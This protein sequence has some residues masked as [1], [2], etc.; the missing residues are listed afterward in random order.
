MKRP[1]VRL[2]ARINLKNG[3][4]AYVDPAWNRNRTLRVG[5]VIV[6]GAIEHHPEAIYYLRFKRPGLRRQSL[7]VGTDL[8]SGSNNFS[9][10]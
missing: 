4:D 10:Y 7:S 5:Y 3:A 9:E 8:D 1:K 6:A 2:Y